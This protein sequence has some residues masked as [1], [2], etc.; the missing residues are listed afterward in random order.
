MRDVHDSLAWADEEFPMPDNVVRVEICTV[1]KK[2][3]N[4]DCPTTFKEAFNVSDVPTTHCPVH[5]GK[6]ASDKRRRIN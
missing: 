3:P 1:S 6:G 2:L 4:D 5:S